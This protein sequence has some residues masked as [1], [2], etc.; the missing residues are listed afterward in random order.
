MF[1]VTSDWSGPLFLG[2]SSELT[3]EMCKKWLHLHCGFCRQ[4]VLYSA[5]VYLWLEEKVAFTWTY[6]SESDFKILHFLCQSFRPSATVSRIGL[7]KLCTFRHGGPP[8]RL[9]PLPLAGWPPCLAWECD[10]WLG[11]SAFTLTKRTCYL[12]SPFYLRDSWSLAIAAHTIRKLGSEK[13]HK[14]N[15]D[16]QTF[17]FSWRQKNAS[18]LRRFQVQQWSAS[19]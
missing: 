18:W 15:K 9:T 4:L 13:L 17:S 6:C 1:F 5:S 11:R 19:Q 3:L 16:P 12:K 2:I 14:T 8:H 7:M 10:G